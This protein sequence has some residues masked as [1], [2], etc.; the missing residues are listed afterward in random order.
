MSRIKT[1]PG[2]IIAELEIGKS[3]KSSIGVYDT[4]KRNEN[5]Y[6]GRQ[7]LGVNAPNLPKPT[8]N[9]LKRVISYF[10]SMIVSDDVSMSVQLYNG[11]NE[12]S[13]ALFDAVSCEIEQTLE[14]NKLKAKNRQ[15]IRNAAVDGDCCI[16]A[17]FD[18]GVKHGNLTDGVIKA[19]L[20]P[21]TNVYFAN[22]YQPD[23]QKQPYILINYVKSAAEIKVNGKAQ[24]VSTKTVFGDVEEKVEAVRK[25]YRKNGTVWITDVC[26]DGVI[27]PPT[28][29]GLR[30]YPIAWM[31]W[32]NVQNCYHGQSPMTSVIQNQIDINRL[33][34]MCIKQVRDAAF[35]KIIYS[36]AMLPD[37]W[38][39]TAG[40]A[41][42]VSGDVNQ[43]VMR[44]TGTAE[45][46]A[47]VI[48][49]INL[50]IS[51]T[52]E[53]M[54]AS[55]AALGNIDPRNTSAIIAVQKSSAMPLELQKQE[56]YRFVEDYIRIFIDIMSV[57]YGPRIMQINGDNGEKTAKIINF[58]QLRDMQLKINVDV[59]AGAYWSELA[60]VA[61]LDNLFSKGI[62]T[63]VV[64]Y[65]ESL[66]SGVLPNREAI[67]KSVR[68]AAEK[69]EK[70]NANNAMQM[71]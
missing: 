54:G 15:A 17:W 44:T 31:S 40:A 3:Y 55:D 37:G 48:N 34:A 29:T 61:T 45:P 18:P 14:I 42:G 58:E 39:N 71:L 41:I 56:F 36:K 67:I 51:C 69:N 70:E 32:D 50:L 62:L 16:Y 21:N 43:A 46:G 5:F 19:E 38:D 49:M 33:F 4:V 64:T 47:Q 60:G 24:P 27:M 68:K 57:N 63:D 6:I 25:L 11:T 12:E 65:L 30:L 10:I 28:D 1:S 9:I 66:P 13:R 7:W 52:K 23:V 26:A 59:G 2:E 8:I 20:L 35:P 22:P 53:T